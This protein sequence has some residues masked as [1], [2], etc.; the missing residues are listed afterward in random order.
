MKAVLRQ[1]LRVLSACWEQ[2][3][4]G[5]RGGPWEKRGEKAHGWPE[6]LCYGQADLGR[7]ARCFPLGPG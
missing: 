5:P 6:F 3:R 7:A 2:K 1:K 4:G